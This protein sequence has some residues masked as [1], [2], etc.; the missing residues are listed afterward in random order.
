MRLHCNKANWE[1]AL[2][3][4]PS[5]AVVSQHPTMRNVYSNVY[6]LGTMYAIIRR[7]WL[8]G[9]GYIASQPRPCCTQL[10]L[11]MDVVACVHV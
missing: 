9:G 2:C 5:P 4:C 11:H 3:V 6:D 10:P 1:S 7:A 8:T